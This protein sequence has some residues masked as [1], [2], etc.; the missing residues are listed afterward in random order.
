MDDV[1]NAAPGNSCCRLHVCGMLLPALPPPV[2]SI[3]VGGATVLIPLLPRGDGLVL[4]P[5]GM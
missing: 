5:V 3:R 4:S 1:L 2:L